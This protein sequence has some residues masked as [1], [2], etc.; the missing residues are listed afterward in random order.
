MQSTTG[1]AGCNAAGEDLP[2]GY[3]PG[4]MQKRKGEKKKT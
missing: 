2:A 3:K 1:A 4:E